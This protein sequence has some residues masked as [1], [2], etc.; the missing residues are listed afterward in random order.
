[1]KDPIVS[2]GGT[3]RPL[4]KLVCGLAFLGFLGQSQ[5]QIVTLVDRNSIAQVNVGSQA[6]MFRWE[7]DGQN[8]LVQQWFWYRIGDA[9]PGNPERSIDTISPP[10]ISTPD[11]K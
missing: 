11:A 6:G 9:V 4:L 2:H 3:R 10:T 1:M 7:A 8:Q 5:A